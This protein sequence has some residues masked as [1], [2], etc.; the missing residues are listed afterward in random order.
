MII[1]GHFLGNVDGKFAFDLV[2]AIVIYFIYPLCQLIRGRHFP[3]AVG[4]VLSLQMMLSLVVA[5]ALEMYERI[6]YW[7]LILHG[8]LGAE[9]ML[10]GYAL[11]INNNGKNM[12]AI[13]R[14]IFLFMFVLGAA[15]LW[16]I[17]EY[18]GYNVTGRDF[19]HMFDYGVNETPLDDT[20]TD[21]LVCISSAAIIYICAVIDHFAGGKLL[22]GVEK[23]L[24]I[25][26]RKNKNDI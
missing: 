8:L 12:T 21:I 1:P 18:V 23:G 14:F 22:Q 7:D 5:D 6:D 4:V 17:C 19:Q 15:A 9:L 3:V 13:G 25:E 26:E 24:L 2:M 20:M 10:F 16:E 11:I